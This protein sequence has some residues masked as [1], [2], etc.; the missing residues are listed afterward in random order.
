MSTRHIRVAVGVF[1][2]PAGRRHLGVVVRTCPNCSAM[3]LRRAEPSTAVDRSVRH[4]SCGTGYVVQ[5][6]RADVLGGVA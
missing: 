1:Y 5:L 6:D 4:G 2:P 3:H